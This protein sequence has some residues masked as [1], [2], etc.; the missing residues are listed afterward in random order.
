MGTLFIQV[1]KKH[2]III[3]KFTFR[4]FGEKKSKFNKLSSVLG[5]DLKEG[6]IKKEEKDKNADDDKFW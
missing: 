4:S 1:L 5:N 3:T 2:E 6:E